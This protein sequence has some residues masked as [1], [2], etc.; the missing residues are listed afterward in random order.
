MIRQK[1]DKILY[2]ITSL[3]CTFFNGTWHTQGY[4]VLGH[5]M[6]GQQSTGIQVGRRGS[7]AVSSDL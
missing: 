3:I 4:T 2:S 6:N 1:T 7:Y 5:N